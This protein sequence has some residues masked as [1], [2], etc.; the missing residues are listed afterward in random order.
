MLY[1]T[2]YSFKKQNKSSNA[3]ALRAEKF[4]FTEKE[5]KSGQSQE[6]D[7][8]NKQEITAALCQHLVLRMGI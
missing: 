1:N 4:A 2:N 6:S 8:S 5:Q 7:S 3:T